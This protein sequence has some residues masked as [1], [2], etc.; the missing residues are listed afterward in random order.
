M[1]FAAVALSIVSLQKV[2]ANQFAVDGPGLTLQFLLPV[3]DLEEVQGKAAGI[4][5]LWLLSA[6]LYLAVAL[7]FL[8]DATPWTAP[9]AFLA[10]VAAYLLAA[11]VAAITSALLPRAADLSK[12]WSRSKPHPIAGLAVAAL[13]LA[14]FAAPAIVSMGRLGAGAGPVEFLI[15]LGSVALAAAGA[16][17]L[18]RVAAEVL[19]RRREEILLAA[20]DR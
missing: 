6:L 20:K 10:G 3:S 19:A 8:L 11:P 4:G 16:L 17:P 15:A 14:L 18:L 5:I 7:P 9:T 1:A 13:S 2:S 12:L